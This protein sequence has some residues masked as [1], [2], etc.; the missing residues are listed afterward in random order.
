MYCFSWL[1]TPRSSDLFLALN[2]RCLRFTSDL[3]V[4]L[5]PGFILIGLSLKLI[6]GSDHSEGSS[7]SFMS[8]SQ[9]HYL[10]NP[11]KITLKKYRNRILLL[12]WLPLRIPFIF[13]LAR[14]CKSVGRDLV[15]CLL[16]LVY[17][18]VC[19]YSIHKSF[20]MVNVN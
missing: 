5:Y 15:S 16:W 10:V 19:W 18:L 12:L 14:T 3:F 1:W 17:S 9:S 11:S 20:K 13:S 7:Q 6:D 8:L 2:L 4:H